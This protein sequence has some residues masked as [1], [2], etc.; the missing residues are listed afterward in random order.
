MNQQNQRS[1]ITQTVQSGLPAWHSKAGE[2]LILSD[3]MRECDTFFY[4]AFGD[5]EYPASLYDASGRRLVDTLNVSGHPNLP[6]RLA[7]STDKVSAPGFTLAE[8]V[9]F[10]IYDRLDRWPNA[11]AQ[12]TFIAVQIDARTFAAMTG[13]KLTPS[14]FDL[15]IHL[16]GGLDLRS[17]AET[18]GAR[19][20]T[21]RKQL[22]QIMDKYGVR[23]QVSLVRKLSVELSA[24]DLDALLRPQ[25]SAPEVALAQDIYGPNIVIHRVSVGTGEEIPIWE[26]GARHGHPILFFHSMVAPLVFNS[27]MVDIL[28]ALNLR[29]QVVPR[30]FIDIL[31]HTNSLKALDLFLGTLAEVVDYLNGEP[32]ICLGESAGCAWATQFARRHP[33]RVSK[34]VLVAT[35]KFKVANEPMQRAPSASGLLNEV[36]VR[37]QADARIVSGLSRIYNSIARNSTLAKRSLNFM[38]R[39]SDADKNS[40]TNAFDELRLGDWLNL[41]ANQ[42]HRSSITE[43]AHLQSRWVEDIIEIDRPILFVHGDEDALCAPEDA[44]AMA[45]SLPNAEFILLPGAGHFALGQQFE[46][47]LGSLISNQN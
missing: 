11:P 40:I 10:Y 31:E 42:A 47:I 38:Y 24:Q 7:V 15:V 17:A 46:K 25:K 37:F 12:V 30:H 28:R 9:L 45:A 29:I 5:C 6:E 19:Y 22:Q 1:Q 26:F 23:T 2:A 20:D 32:V 34:V 43:V 14:E 36:A 27:E 13:I 8:G 33:Q 18:L 44:Q 41:I 16:I 3:E 35:P 4:R 21:K 39:K